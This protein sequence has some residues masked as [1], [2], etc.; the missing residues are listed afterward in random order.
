MMNFRSLVARL[1]VEQHQLNRRLKK[2]TRIIDALAP[3]AGNTIR[4]RRRISKAARRKMSQAKKAFW[5][6]KKAQ[7]RTSKKLKIAA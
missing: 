5:A 6:K 3:L 2:V 4:R 1:R 7:Q